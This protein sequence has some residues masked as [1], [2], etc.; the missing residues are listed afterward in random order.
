[1]KLSRHSP[2]C[3]SLGQLLGD[4]SSDDLL[5]RGS[6]GVQETL[7]LVLDK[8]VIGEWGCLREVRIQIFRT[9]LP[10]S[11]TVVMKYKL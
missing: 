3:R 8:G 2:H 11:S 5:V 10:S 4:S 9:V 7:E 6:E 1:M